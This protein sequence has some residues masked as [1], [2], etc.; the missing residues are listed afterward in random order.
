MLFPLGCCFCTFPSFSCIS[1]VTSV[2]V[3][4]LCAPFVLIFCQILPKPSFFTLHIPSW[5]CI[6][7]WLHIVSVHWWLPN[8]SFQPRSFS[9]HLPDLSHPAPAICLSVPGT[10]QAQHVKFSSLYHLSNKRPELITCSSFGG[11]FLSGQHQYAPTCPAEMWA[12]ALDS[13]SSSTE[14]SSFPHCQVLLNLMLSYF[15]N[16]SIFS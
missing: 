14:P 1:L 16:M 10:C 5:W 11:V 6:V 3:S 8:P 9:N 15:W 7:P 13:S 4:F 2:C 12:S